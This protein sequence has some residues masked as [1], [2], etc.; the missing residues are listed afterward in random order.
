MKHHLSSL[1]IIAAL[2][3]AGCSHHKTAPLPTEKGVSM[4]LNNIRKESISKLVYKLFF[5]IPANKNTPI[6]GNL[7]LNFDLKNK[8]FPVILDFQNPK[9]FVHKVMANGKVSHYG[10]KN[11]HLIIPI[12]ELKKGANTLKINFTAGNLSLNRNNNFLYTL[13]VP[14]RASTAFP[15]FDQPDLKANFDLSLSI[16]KDWV[17][18][19]NG[20]QISKKEEGDNT[21]LKFAQTKPLSTYLFAFVAGKFHKVSR[22]INNRKLTF[23]YRETDSA[24]VARNL[25]PIF[26]LE[27]HAI[28][29]MEKYTG[30]PYPF[31]KFAFVAIPAFQYGG[32]EHPGAILYKADRI[33]LDKSATQIQKL[34]RAIVISHETA[35][36][37]FGD[38]VTM[39]WFNDVWLKEVFANFFAAKIANP[40]FPKMNH[41]LSFLV[42]HFP[43][44][45]LIDRSAGA[46]PIQQHLTNLKMAGTLYGNIIYHKAPI[47]MKMLEN[48][49]GEQKFQEGLRTYLKKYSY[50]NASWD[51]LISILDQKTSLDLANWS[52]IWVK[53]PGMPHYQTSTDGNKLI[54]HQSNA[55]KTGMIW[56][57]YFHVLNIYNGKI[58]YSKIFAD[59]AID[60]LNLAKNPEV[61]LLNGEGKAYGYFKLNKKQKTFL[62]SRKLFTLPPLQRAVA[63]IS[64][65]ENMQQQN[66]KPEDLYRAFYVFLLNEK[67]ELNVNLLLGYYKKLFWRFS[68]AQSRKTLESKFEPLLWHKMQKAPDASMKSSYYH[69]WLSTALSKHAIQKMVKLWKGTLKIKGLPLSEGDMTTL[70]YQLAVRINGKMAKEIPSNILQQQLKKVKDPDR[71]AQMAYTIPALSSDSTVRDHFFYALRNY[72]QREH[73]AWVSTALYYLNH[74]LRAKSSEK[75]ITPALDLLPEVQRTG[76]VFFPK[77]WLDASLYGYNS[78]SAAKLIRDYLAKNQD[79]N[80]KLRQ[81]VLQSADPVFRAAAILQGEKEGK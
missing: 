72:A 20:A 17:A 49:V 51:D 23:Y 78:K 33:F 60:T 77:S 11:G 7:E 31:G 13:F 5:K 27:A 42:D 75:Y 15:C 56:P 34:Y 52:K 68:T 69:A 38:L 45:Y 10:F 74:P 16:P 3:L 32:M 50:S 36:M 40:D 65:W 18:V 62:L 58:K 66:L 70:S 14:A 25:D 55:Q 2:I 35:H 1:L 12:N 81:K 54:I 63:Y 30:I 71:K 73:Q 21:L 44:A 67:D 48:L 79:L 41:H 28:Q 47:I 57:Q 59:K 64:I 6:T 80:P 37:W 46:N 19:A 24:K 61:L 29:W 26:H 9:Q 4:Q 53:E 43:P 39:K 76:D 22:T 8:N